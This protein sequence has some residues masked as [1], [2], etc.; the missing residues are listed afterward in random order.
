M[1]SGLRFVLLLVLSC[2]AAA[3]Q[4]PSP[5][6]MLLT[7]QVAG[8]TRASTPL[9]TLVAGQTVQ[10][11]SATPQLFTIFIHSEE[12]ALVDKLDRPGTWAAPD[13][14]LFYFVALNTGA[15]DA[16]VKF[17]EMEPPQ[18]GRPAAP[19]KKTITVRIFFATDRKPTSRTNVERYFANMP[20]PQEAL[21]YG[22]ADVSIPSDHRIGEL[23]DSLVRKLGFADSKTVQLESCQPL[24]KDAFFQSLAEQISRPE[25]AQVLVFVHGFN[26]SFE[27][28]A[29]RLGQVVYDL[30]FPGPAVLFSW[31]SRSEVLSY[32][33]DRQQA[34]KSGEHV[35]AFF[36]DLFQTTKSVPVHILA[37]SMGNAVLG[38]ALQKLEKDGTG[39]PQFSEM[40]LMAPDLDYTG[41][42]QRATAWRR[43]AR[44]ITLYA[45]SNDWAL[46]ISSWVNGKPRAGRPT[47]DARIIPGVDLVDVSRGGP[48]Q[49]LSG[50][51][52]NHSYFG[53]SRT[54]LSDLFHVIRGDPPNGRFGLSGVSNND[55]SYLQI[56]P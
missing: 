42:F 35:A 8:G 27:D 6:R 54:I 1:K 32:R 12:G 26:V 13:N 38:A 33:V 36:K 47:P 16:S 7:L 24:Y 49:E 40:M 2:A 10:I 4:P 37:H 11:E 20:D 28:A 43:F 21:S 31:A 44:R 18:Q 3:Q 41:F 15:D 25:R 5:P 52:L 48:K 51:G 22:Y 55:G 45:S 17:T 29:R 14:G 39:V 9:L 23:E 34:P 30:A 50:F 19:A 53:D 46:L 56:R